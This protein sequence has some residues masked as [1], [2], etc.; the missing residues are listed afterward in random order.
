MGKSENLNIVSIIRHGQ[1]ESRDD[2]YFIDME[3]GFF[4]LETYIK[5]SFDSISQDIDWVSLQACS[6]VIVQRDCSPIAKIENWCT[7]G[8]H[9]ALGLKYLHSHRYVHR[10]LK[11]ANGIYYLRK[12]NK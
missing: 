7:I 9:I 8:A 6:P 4:T 3:L 2:Y 5:S 12:S 10:D 1:L 11:P